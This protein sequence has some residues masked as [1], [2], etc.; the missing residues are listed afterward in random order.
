MP[1]VI[2]QRQNA[3]LTHSIVTRELHE[4]VKRPAK[5]KSPGWDGIRSEFFQVCY[6]QIQSQLLGAVQEVLN[7]GALSEDLNG[8]ITLI[9]KGGDLTQVT[10]YRPITLLGT[11]YK[12][13]AKLLASR[14]QQLLPTIV[15]PN[16]TG[17]V[18]GRCI[19]DNIFLAQESLTWAENSNQ[20]LVLLLLDFDKAFDRID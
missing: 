10:N 15:R 11:F 14:L 18:Q 5:N 16:Q 2:T 17:Y 7:T 20:E 6:E 3:Q 4:A 9:P 13:V 1:K 12:I 19:I 8:L